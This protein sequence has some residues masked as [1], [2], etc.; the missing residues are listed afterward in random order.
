MSGRLSVPEQSWLTVMP[1]IRGPTRD[2]GP[3]RTEVPES[4]TA[5]YWEASVVLPSLETL[6]IWRAQYFSS[7]T[8]WKV[9]SSAVCLS[10]SKPG[11]VI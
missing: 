10:V 4:I 9:K 7:T 3:T 1:S 11:I 6:V 2:L 5:L 8:L